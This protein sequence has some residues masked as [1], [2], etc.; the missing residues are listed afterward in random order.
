MLEINV[1]QQLGPADIYF[2]S[3][4]PWQVMSRQSLYLPVD[5]PIIP[6]HAG[7]IGI[8]AMPFPLYAKG[9]E[10]PCIAGGKARFLNQCDSGCVPVMFMAPPRAL[11][12][13]FGLFSGA[14]EVF[15]HDIVRRGTLP[16]TCRVD[17][18]VSVMLI[19]RAMTVTRLTEKEIEELRREMREAGAW[20]REELRRRRQAGQR[21]PPG[22]SK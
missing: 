21:L 1:R 12:C 17:T 16:R 8:S 11:S 22:S 19:E 13:E 4:P 2:Q 6:A 14:F 3:P 7:C 10:I 20:A 15:W 18:C 9:L 5:R